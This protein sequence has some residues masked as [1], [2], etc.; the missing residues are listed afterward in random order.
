MESSPQRLKKFFK[1][2]KDLKGKVEDSRFEDLKD[3]NIKFETLKIKFE[4][5][6]IKIEM[7]SIRDQTFIP[8]VNVIQ[9]RS[10]SNPR[11]SKVQVQIEDMQ[12]S[13]PSPLHTKVSTY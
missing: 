8:S 1:A 12:K 6:K 4:V 10:K 9:L 7:F 11:H 5:S 2:F 3:L 13:R